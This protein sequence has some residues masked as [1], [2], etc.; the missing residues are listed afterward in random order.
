M[1]KERSDVANGRCLG[2]GGV[3]RCAGVTTPEQSPT[4][5]CFKKQKVKIK[6]KKKRIGCNDNVIIA[7][8]AGKL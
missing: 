6:N 2:R 7:I 3:G 5:P 4:S 8:Y 1:S